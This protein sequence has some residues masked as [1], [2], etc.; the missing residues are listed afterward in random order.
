M[1]RGLVDSVERLRKA[2]KSD[3]PPILDAMRRQAA[4]LAQVR[5]GK[6]K[7]ASSNTCQLNTATWSPRLFCCDA[8]N[9][10]TPHCRLLGGCPYRLPPPRVL[11]F[12]ATCRYR[13]SI[14]FLLPALT[15]RR[16]TSIAWWRPSRGEEIAAAGE[17]AGRP[18]SEAGCPRGAGWGRAG[19][20]AQKGALPVV[21]PSVPFR[22]RKC[23]RCMHHD[24]R[25][26]SC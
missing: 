5:A 19:G 23:A 8:A 4:D 15:A 9:I 25:E 2:P 3:I 21:R 1:R 7:P 18:R 10:T 13:V 22:A 12:P 20:K 11:C 6:L 14:P 16:R 17:E 24:H 26:I